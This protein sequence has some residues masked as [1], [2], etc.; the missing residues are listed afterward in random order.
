MP[1]PI[2]MA[3]DILLTAARSFPVIYFLTGH[4]PKSNHPSR[5]SSCHLSSFELVA[6]HFIALQPSLFLHL[7]HYTVN[8]FIM[9]HLFSFFNYTWHT[10]PYQFQVQ[11]RLNIYITHKV[12]TG[13]SLAPPGTTCSYNINNVPYAALYIPETVSITGNVRILIPS[14]PSSVPSNPLICICLFIDFFRFHMFVKLC[15]IYLSLTSFTYNIL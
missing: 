5:F 13:V 15:G 1:P 4:R 11:N 10:I 12:I 3:Y 2:T 7:P 8:F 14:P 9:A 6:T